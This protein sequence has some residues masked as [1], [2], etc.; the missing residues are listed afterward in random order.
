[1]RKAVVIVLLFVAG[2]VFGQEFTFQGLPWGA[3]KEQVIA[4]LGEPGGRTNNDRN[5]YYLVSLSGYRAQLLISFF[6]NNGLDH[7]QYSI[8]PYK[9]LNATSILLL[10][11][12]HI[13]SIS[14]CTFLVV[15]L[16][17]KYP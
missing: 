3:T 2:A 1:M 5:F 16:Y 17:S 11:S 9:D 6:G 4:K 12:F 14:S 10:I 13:L 7:S 8:N 15:P